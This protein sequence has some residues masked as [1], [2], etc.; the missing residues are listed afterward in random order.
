MKKKL[1]NLIPISKPG[2]KKLLL[3]M[4]LALV[5]IFLSVLQVSANVFAQVNVNLDI[6]EK[7]VREVLKT[8]E[9][10]S[11]VRFFYSDDLLAMNELIDV[12]ADN[13]NI[14]SVLDDIFSNSP[15]AYKAFDNNLIVIA[16]RQMLQQ[17]KIT[18]IVTDKKSGDALPGVNV[19]VQGTTSGDIT[20]ANGKYTIAVTN[21]NVNLEFSFIGYEKVTVPINGQSVINVQLVNNSTLLDEVV[22]VGYGVQRRRDV[23]GATTTLKSDVI[24]SRPITRIDQALQGTTPGVSV[25]S[26]SGQPGTMLSVRIRGTNSITGSNDPLYVIDGYIGGNIESISPED[27]ESMEILKDASAT[28]IYGSRGSNG[29][30]LITTKTGKEGKMKVDFNTWFSKASMPKYLDLMNAYDF[31]STVNAQFAANGQAPAF[32]DAQLQTIKANG[33]GTDW[34]K[35]VTQ[36]PLI[37]NYQLSVSGGTSVVK[38]LFSGSFLDQPGLLLNQWYKKGSFRANVDVKASEKIDLKFNLTGLQSQNRNTDYSGDLYDP[39]TLAFQWDPTT[40]IRDGNGNYN[41]HSSYGSIQINPVA[42]ANNRMSDNTTNNFTGTGMVIYHILKSLTFTSSASYEGQFQYTPQ[43]FGPQTNTGL[44]GNDHATVNNIRYRSFQN[45]NFFTYKNDFGDHS[46]T[47][48]ALYEQLNRQNINVQAQAN[49]LSS[50]ANGYYNLGLGGTQTISSGYWSDALQS[51]MGR[52]NYSYKQKY[53]LTASIRDDGSSHLTKKYSLFPS[54]ALA[55]NINKE[56]FLQDSKAISTLKL[57]VGY[58]KT[59]NQAVPAYATIPSIGVGIPYYFNGTTP[60]VTTPLGT[61]V[62]SDL[63]WETTTQYDAGIDAGFLKDRLTFTADIYNKKISDLLYD[64]PAPDYLGGG[65]YKRNIGSLGNKGIELSI[66]G[67]PVS[68]SALKWN[69]Y[70]TISFNQNKV[71]DLGGLDNVQVNGVG[72]PQ[73]GLSILKVGMPLGEFY[74]YHFLGTWKTS[75][76]AE[77]AL[78]GLKPGDAKYTDVNGDHSY[79]VADQM[80]IGNG[81]PKYSFGFTND[82]T[83]GNFTLSFMFQGEHGNQIF[84]TSFPYTYGGLG[85]TKNATSVDAKNMWTPTN[86]TDFPVIGST[87]NKLNSSRYVYDASFIKLKNFSLAY[88][89]PQSLLNKVNISNLEVYVSGQNILCFTKYKGYDPEVTTAQNAITQ[90]LETGSIPNPKTLTIGLKASF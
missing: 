36:S 87:S 60:T 57:R 75:E 5:I 90:G 88:H 85:D 18:G 45:S 16:P 73:S 44:S 14:L 24:A 48:T 74:G 23:T 63:K 69:T 79:T 21:N 46:I 62:S 1:Q 72:S 22:V 47:L 28:A 9:Q 50:Y 89:L 77:A 65:T 41:L 30:V 84:S 76:A 54:V 4:K 61:A 33:N 53:D 59:G 68:T 10:Q 15:L 64:Y 11:Q 43:L 26:N 39:F 67:V 49:K 80:P 78:F 29:V 34:Q 52:I 42:E 51:Y 27:I 82:V 13:K 35:A 81:M 3:T 6:R 58:G 25:S 55:W 71:L 38:Y 31:A 2:I 83:Y 56:S 19:V 17:Q 20:D 66:G 32:S 40:P 37:Q 86:E 8:I 12:K 7:S 70:F